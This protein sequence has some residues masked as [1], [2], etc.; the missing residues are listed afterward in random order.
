M[1]RLTATNAKSSKTST[2]STLKNPQKYTVEQCEKDIA[3]LFE[4]SVDKCNNSKMVIED[5]FASAFDEDDEQG[6]GNHY[7]NTK[8]SQEQSAAKSNRC[9]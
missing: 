1:P 2:R 6:T 9:T 7:S 4:S 5:M 3:A 8:K